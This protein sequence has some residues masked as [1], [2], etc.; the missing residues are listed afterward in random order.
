M[1]EKLEKN[2]YL[3]ECSHVRAL[4]KHGFEELKANQL[5][6]KYKFISFIKNYKSAPDAKPFNIVN[7]C[8]YPGA[9]E[10]GKNFLI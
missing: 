6:Y 9:N 8:N 10:V 2:E 4:N 5:C 3:G 1:F 7:A